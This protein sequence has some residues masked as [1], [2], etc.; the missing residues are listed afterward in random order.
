MGVSIMTVWRWR[1]ECPWINARIAAESNDYVEAVRHRFAKMLPTAAQAIEEIA[2]D[3]DHKDRLS[4][5][6][7][8]IDIFRRDAIRDMSPAGI[9]AR[10]KEVE[11][12]SDDALDRAI[13][14][15]TAEEVD[16]K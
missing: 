12:L 9:I 4:A 15:T 10:I 6:K 13:L 8:V 3:P 1:D 14:D 7:T 2:S 5:A 11:A 16:P